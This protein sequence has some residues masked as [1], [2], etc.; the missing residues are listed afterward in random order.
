MENGRTDPL[1]VADDFNRLLQQRLRG[2]LVSH[3]IPARR[4]IAAHRPL[5]RGTPALGPTS[6]LK[7]GNVCDNGGLRE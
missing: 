2:F 3:R 1:P 6:I 4:W 7:T 5:H